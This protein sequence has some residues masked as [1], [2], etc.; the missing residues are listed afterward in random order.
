MFAFRGCR[1]ARRA[2]FF[3][4]T[5]PSGVASHATLHAE[6]HTAIACDV[7]G[8]L[9]ARKRQQACRCGR[10]GLSEHPFRR[11]LKQLFTGWRKDKTFV[12]ATV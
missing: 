10:P 2:I 5:T 6:I 11:M 3:A 1:V 9:A 4:S 12:H 8:D 7:C